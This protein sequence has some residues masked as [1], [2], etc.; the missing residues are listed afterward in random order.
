MKKSSPSRKI[1]HAPV[2]YNRARGPNSPCGLDTVPLIINYYYH[3]IT[4]LI[5]KFLKNRLQD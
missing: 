3:S 1:F 5:K 4:Q 2:Y